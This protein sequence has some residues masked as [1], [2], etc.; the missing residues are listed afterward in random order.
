VQAATR[1][2][3]RPSRRLAVLLLALHFAALAAL[4][5]LT[6]ALWIRIVLAVALMAGLV[7]ALR[8][9]ALLRSGDAVVELSCGEDG[10]LGCAQRDG[11][12]FDAE[13]LPQTAVY[14][15][16]VLLRA[17]PAGARRARSVVVLPDSLAAE[18]F[19]RLRVWLRWRRPVSGA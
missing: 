4:A 10:R 18:D 15:A 1:L 13:V 17:K 16:A 9:S 11:A 3:L 19:R 8:R 14:A 5:A 6:F 2:R 7:R 12:R